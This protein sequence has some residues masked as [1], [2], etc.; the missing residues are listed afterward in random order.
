MASRSS[1]LYDELW[2]YKSD[3]DGFFSTPVVHR[4]SDTSYSSTISCIAVNYMDC[5]SRECGR[6]HVVYSRQKY[7][8][9]F[10]VHKSYMHGDICYTCWLSSLLDELSINYVKVTPMAS[11]NHS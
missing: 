2:M 3:S 6:R 10:F 7:Y 1:S 4:S 5:G 9:E 11:F 8:V